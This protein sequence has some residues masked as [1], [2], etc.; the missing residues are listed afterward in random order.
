MSSLWTPSGEHEVPRDRPAAAGA[1]SG[2]HDDGQLDP[3]ND[4]EVQAFLRSQAEAM[5]INLDELSPEER[6]QTE[7]AIAEMIMTR[8]RLAT[9]PASEV[10][11][12][13]AMGIYELAAIHLSQE[14]PNFPEA[15]VA[16]DALAALYE[17]VG[18]RLGENGPVI[19][20][21]LANIQ[22]A[23]VQMSK[24]AKEASE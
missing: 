15:A 2:E 1:P 21:A 9:V 16:I 24:Q 6:Q 19:Q 11:A 3:A 5:G 12:N 8:Q 4:A 22:T 23:F 7:A 13:H 18:E 17:R 14:T 10:I 20:Q